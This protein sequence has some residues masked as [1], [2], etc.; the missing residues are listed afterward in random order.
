MAVISESP[1]PRFFILPW[2]P[3]VVPEHA[4]YTCHLHQPVLR[5][6]HDSRDL[7]TFTRV[8]LAD[9]CKACLSVLGH[10][11]SLHVTSRHQ[12]SN[13]G[14][15]SDKPGSDSIAVL[16]ASKPRQRDDTKIRCTDRALEIAYSGSLGLDRCHLDIA[17]SLSR[18]NVD[19]G[20]AQ[21]VDRLW[22]LVCAKR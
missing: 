17:P 13:S 16:L 19:R 11:L 21:T 20:A 3:C 18:S 12:R 14:Q 7:A 8:K 10:H 1:S 4:S 9:R 15:H 6:Q 22:R 5:F 2:L